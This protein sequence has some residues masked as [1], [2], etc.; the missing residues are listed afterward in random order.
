MLFLQPSILIA[1]IAPAGRSQT[2][3][4]SMWAFC[5]DGQ[6]GWGSNLPHGD[7]DHWIRLFCIYLYRINITIHK[8]FVYNVRFLNQGLT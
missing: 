2:R 7:Q 8:L 6:Y 5:F 4:S 1:G 3:F